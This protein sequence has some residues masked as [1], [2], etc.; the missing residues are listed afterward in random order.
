MQ[1]W[2]LYSLI[3]TCLIFFNNVKKEIFLVTPMALPHFFTGSGI[4][5]LK[6]IQEDVIYFWVPKP[7]PMYLLVMFYLQLAQ[8]NLTWNLDGLRTQFWPKCFF[9]LY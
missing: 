3:F 9:H 1:F 2:I 7:E 5:I 4:V 6:P 8:K